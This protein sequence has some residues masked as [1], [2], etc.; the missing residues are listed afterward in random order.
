MEQK[1]LLVPIVLCWNELPYLKNLIPQL[2]KVSDEII[3]VDG[4]STDGTK[5]WFDFI[6]NPKVKFCQRAFDCCANQFDYALQKAPKDNTWVYNVTGDELPTIWFFENIRRILDDADSKKIDRLF[7]TVF[8]LRGE[9][10]IS[11]EIGGQLRL[12]RNDAHHECVYTDY[13]RERLHGH[14]DGHCIMQTDP[15]FAFVHFRQADPQKVELWKT[16]YIEKG[17]YSLW[18]INRRLNIETIPLDTDIDYKI[19]NE[20][21]EYLKW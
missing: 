20:L 2:E 7:M 13:P 12:F 21:R 5:E 15:K 19:T 10:E 1:S 4:N 8:H 14:F 16:H 9:R 6:I 18:D 17:V 3:I 11:N